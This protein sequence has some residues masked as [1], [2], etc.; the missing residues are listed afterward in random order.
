MRGPQMAFLK[1]AFVALACTC[2]AAGPAVFAE[3]LLDRNGAQ[4]VSPTTGTLTVEVGKGSLIR[5]DRAATEIFIANPDIADVQVKSPRV[6]YILGK[7][8]GETSLY[9]LDQ[10]DQTIFSSTVTVTRNLGALRSAY[11]RMLPGTPIEV[12]TLGQLIVLQGNVS[13]PDEAALAEQLARSVLDTDRVLNS[14]NVL[15]PTQV[16]LRVRIA[17]VSRSVLKQLGI[18]W[19]GGLFNS[20]FGIGLAQGR[21]VA[22]I[23][24]DPVTNLPKK[25]FNLP[26]E[27]FALYGDVIGSNLD[28]NYAIDALDTEGFLKVLAEPNLTALTGQAANFLAGGEFPIPVPSKDGIGIEYREFGVKLDFTPTV[29]NSGRISMKVRPEVSDLSSAGAIRVSGISV[30]SISTRRAETTIELGSGQS[31][32]IAGLIQNNVVQDAS[33]FPGLGDLPILG[34]LFRSEQFRHEETELLIVVTPYVVQPVSDRQLVLPTDRF[35]TPKDMD[36]YLKDRRW[37]PTETNPVGTQDTGKGP[38]LK[39]RAGFVLK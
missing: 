18:N 24:A 14:L 8:Q 21:N 27:N 23:V 32:A 35:V 13:A 9:A 25:V 38:S 10:D 19:E 26:T 5:L 34:A 6:V 31:F 22:D 12:T 11:A 17:E 20:S 2:A 36:R 4:V 1:Q 39:K 29:M 15:Q 37:E 33:K 16:N 7:M 28:L 3:P 30:P